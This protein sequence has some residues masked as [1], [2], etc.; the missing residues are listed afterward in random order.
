MCCTTINKCAYCPRAKQSFNICAEL[1]R[2][3]DKAVIE[4]TG[5]TS[6]IHIAR[7]N[8]TNTGHVT[9]TACAECYPVVHSHVDST[10]ASDRIK[11]VAVFHGKNGLTERVYEEVKI[12]LNYGD[13]GPEG[14]AAENSATKSRSSILVHHRVSWLESREGGCGLQQGDCHILNLAAELRLKIYEFVYGDSNSRITIFMYGDDIKDMNVVHSYRTVQARKDLTLTCRKISKEVIPE[15]YKT[16][17][18]KVEI[19][20]KRAAELNWSIGAREGMP[21]LEKVKNV[22]DMKVICHLAESV[23]SV[24]NGIER[25]I[26]MLGRSV[27]QKKVSVIETEVCIGASMLEDDTTTVKNALLS[28]DCKGVVTV[29][30]SKTDEAEIRE[31]EAMQFRD[32][33]C[34]GAAFKEWGFLEEVVVGRMAEVSIEG[35]GGEGNGGEG[36]VGECDYSDLDLYTLEPLS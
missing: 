1:K 20:P 24:V 28:L 5:H 19:Y 13:E 8:H 32:S 15:L 2:S 6:K 33:N 16:V 3:V 18:F 21:F 35:N 10:E 17:T 9:T 4:D 27:E 25:F 22:A 30:R 11:L 26:G 12:W 34:Q 14:I 7:S 23:G 31:R 36:G 29:T